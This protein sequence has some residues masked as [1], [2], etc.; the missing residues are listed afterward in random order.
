[1]KK[2]IRPL[3]RPYIIGEGPQSNG[4]WGMFCPLHEDTTRSASINFNAGLWFCHAGCGGGTIKDLIE[5]RDEWV[6]PPTTSAQATSPSKRL[7]NGTGPTLSAA[8]VAGYHQALLDTESALK[9]FSARRGLSK[10]TL[11]Q[12]QI[13]YDKDQEAYTIPVYDSQDSLINL[14]RYQLDPPDQR[15]K[16]WSIKGMGS[17]ALYPVSSLASDTIVICEGELDALLTIQHGYS[18]VTRTGGAK[19]WRSE[20]NQHFKGKKVYVCHDMDDAG[21]DANLIVERALENIA[22]EITVL[23][24]PYEITSKH[25]KDLTDYWLEHPEADL[26]NLG[27]A[28]D[29]TSQAPQEQEDVR[30]VSILD[31]HDSARV[32]QPLSLT[33]TIKGRREPGYTIPHEVTY[34]CT[35]DAGKK[36]ASCP[37]QTLGKAKKNI[38]PSDPIVLD[39]LDATRMQNS[40]IL[41]E[42]QGLPKCSKLSIDVDTYQAVEILIAR[43]SIDVS[44]L[45]HDSSDFKNLKI[46][47]VGRHDTSA[48]NTVKVTGSLYPAPKTQLNEFLVWDIE[49]V[50]TTVDSFEMDKSIAR[51]LRK[52]RPKRGQ[53]PLEKYTEISNNLA[54]HVTNIYGRDEMHSAIDLA[55]HSALAFDFLGRRI[56]RGWLEVLIVGDTR[57]GKSAAAS[58]LC[59]HYRVG[60]VISCEASSYAG[61]IGG[62]QQ[63]GG[64]KEWAITWGSLPLNDGRLVVLDEVSGLSPDEIGA[65]SSVRSSGEAQITKVVSDRTLARVRTIWIGNPRDARM[66]DYTYGCQSIKSLIGNNEDIARFD[67]ALSVSEG[68]V[69]ASEINQPV[70]PG[71]LRYPSQSCSDLIKWIWSRKPEQIKWQKVAEQT[72]LDEAQKLGSKYVERPPLVQVADVREKIARMSVAMAGRLF[73]STDKDQSIL[74]TP[75]HV[76]DTVELIDNIYSMHSFGYRD[77]SAEWLQDREE[78]A[79]NRK[80]ITQYLRE[81]E[82]LAKFLR[83]TS[84]FRRADLEEILNTSKE[85][86]NAKINKLWTARMI[87]KE[88][89]DIKPEPILNEILRE[90]R[91]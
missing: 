87:R 36:C 27:K 8:A 16:I 66:S 49:P 17:T 35:R 29:K 30:P 65:M 79:G 52:F 39:F 67:L 22:S 53:R 45:E 19:N 18:A 60:E 25:G 31:S 54:T 34:K 32:G 28:L 51:E 77:L 80:Q 4:E 73:S 40:T 3:L 88:R 43:P 91:E 12:Y 44:R 90:V 50:E 41:R 7:P 57:T 23:H 6:D 26:L 14:R 76:S 37:L 82:R 62:L 72:V 9:A 56:S 15:R 69:S 86:A 68:E 1:M 84:G 64:S 59:D 5:L 47:S 83:S 38:E 21:Q 24:L 81:E 10:R 42:L 74:V 33:V 2:R 63:Y 58:K 71:K 11:A 89:G 13:G 70:K 78:A 46:T 48:N 61:I 75:K 20:W 85:D 55:F